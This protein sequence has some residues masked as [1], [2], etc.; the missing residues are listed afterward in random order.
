M[1]LLGDMLK[2]QGGVGWENHVVE[3]GKC[4]L[5]ARSEGMNEHETRARC[6][7]ID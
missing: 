6:L 2:P 5:L 1:Y 4:S 7:G 3:Q